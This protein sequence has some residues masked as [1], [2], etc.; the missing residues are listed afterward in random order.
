MSHFDK[1]KQKISTYT[2]ANRLGFV[3]KYSDGNRRSNWRF[4]DVQKLRI[5]TIYPVK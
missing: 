1:N 3:T 5:A 2:L 4:L